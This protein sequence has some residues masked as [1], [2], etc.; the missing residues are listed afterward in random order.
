MILHSPLV[1]ANLDTDLTAEEKLRYLKMQEEAE[2]AIDNERNFRYDANCPKCKEFKNIV[3]EFNFRTKENFELTL[4]NRNLKNTI[5][6]L[7]NELN[8]TS[9]VLKK[10]NQII[11][12]TVPKTPEEQMKI[13]CSL[14]QYPGE[15]CISPKEWLYADF[16]LYPIM[17]GNLAWVNRIYFFETNQFFVRFSAESVFFLGLLQPTLPLL[18]QENARQSQRCVIPQTPVHDFQKARPQWNC[19]CLHRKITPKCL[20][21]LWPAKF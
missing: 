2:N 18:L 14:R 15:D 17:T 4:E 7:A 1:N 12:E 9:E 21:K 10:A 19:R 8:L 20:R 16:S 11:N 6:I 5:D 3:E 13:V